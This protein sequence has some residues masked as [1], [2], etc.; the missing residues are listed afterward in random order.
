M[1][2]MIAGSDRCCFNSIWVESILKGGWAQTESNIVDTTSSSL[3]FR[4]IWWI[5]SFLHVDAVFDLLVPSRCSYMLQQCRGIAN[6][7]MA[8]AWDALSHHGRWRKNMRCSSWLF[9]PITLISPYSHDIPWHHFHRDTCQVLARLWK[10]WW[11]ML[12][13]ASMPQSWQLQ[14]GNMLGAGFNFQWTSM[15]AAVSLRIMGKELNNKK[16]WMPT[17]KH[18][19]FF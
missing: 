8:F 4:N 19:V 7:S 11:A 13:K 10:P 2:G 12:A 9:F 16:T 1:R 17:Q 18:D 6:W 15:D 3:T 14:L 5:K